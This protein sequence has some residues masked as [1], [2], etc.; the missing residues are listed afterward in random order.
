MPCSGPSSTTP[1]K[2]D[3]VGTVVSCLTSKERPGTHL[4][5]VIRVRGAIYWSR[6]ACTIQRGMSHFYTTWFPLEIFDLE[7]YFYLLI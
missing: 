7:H 6:R 3:H 2:L 1:N 4:R 5:H